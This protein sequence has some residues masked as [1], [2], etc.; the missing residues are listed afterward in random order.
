MLYHLVEEPPPL[1]HTLT[2]PERPL[3]PLRI[4]SR[5]IPDAKSAVLCKSRL[6]IMPTYDARPDHP[7]QHGRDLGHRSLRSWAGNQIGAAEK[8]ST[9]TTATDMFLY[10]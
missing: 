7:N 5:A 8:N 4:E 6:R 1:V 10:A 9:A 3:K 2:R